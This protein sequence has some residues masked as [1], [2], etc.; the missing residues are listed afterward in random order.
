MRALHDAAIIRINDENFPC[1]SLYKT[2]CLNKPPDEPTPP[3][4][5]G[6][7]AVP[8]TKIIRAAISIDRRRRT[9]RMRR[10][11]YKSVKQP[12]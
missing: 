6:L 10:M 3:K 12:N 4:S 1:L 7:I 2:Y 5:P 9:M 11:G 8:L